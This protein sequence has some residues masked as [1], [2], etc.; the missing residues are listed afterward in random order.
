MSRKKAKQNV[1]LDKVR[2][3]MVSKDIIAEENEGNLDEAMEA[4]KD[5]HHVVNLQKGVVVDVVDFI[6]PL[7]SVKG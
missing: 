5:L 3:R 1:D 6:K 2:K 4:Y 7:I